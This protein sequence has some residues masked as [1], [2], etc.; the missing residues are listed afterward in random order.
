MTTHTYVYDPTRRIISVPDARLNRMLVRDA[1]RYATL[2][3][4]SAGAGLPT[5]RV[6]SLLAAHLDDGTLGL[7]VAGGEIFLLTAP[8]GRPVPAD[9]GDVAPNLWETFRAA[10]DVEES[11]RLWR[12]CRSMERAGWDM[13]VVASVIAYGLGPVMTAPKLGCLVGRTIVPLVIAPTPDA[14][15]A[16]TGVLAEYDRAG[17]TAV[18]LVCVQGA[19]DSTVTAARRYLLG[20]RVNPTALSVVVLEAPRYQPV[21]LSAGDSGVTPRSLDRDL[22]AS[23]I[24][25]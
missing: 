20:R 13:E 22:L 24:G 5:D 19:L 2:S 21:L 17:A 15:A 25:R 11:C 3:E 9:L 23:T 10:A 1:H 4:Y 7:E 16:P 8:R 14:V 18:G 12:I 6:V